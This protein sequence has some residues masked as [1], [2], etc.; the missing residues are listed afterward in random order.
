M[1]K[2]CRFKF[3]ISSGK[4]RKK[5]TQTYKEAA[6]LSTS[7]YSTAVLSLLALIHNLQY[8]KPKSVKDAWRLK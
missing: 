2:K 6:V 4:K 5:T 7:F 3:Y 1:S 8:K